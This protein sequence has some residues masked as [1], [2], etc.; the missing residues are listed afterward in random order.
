MIKK[1]RFLFNCFVF[2]HLRVWLFFISVES[3]LNYQLGFEYWCIW[4]VLKYYYFVMWKETT[5]KSVLTFV[6]FEVAILLSMMT[7]MTTIPTVCVCSV[8]FALV[9]TITVKQSE[10][11]QKI[12]AL[13]QATNTC[14]TFL[15]VNAARRYQ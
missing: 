10:T 9:W 11:P 15:I 5:T 8:L 6:L 7:E 4:L 12:T 14:F 2:V 1:T 13:I 3:M